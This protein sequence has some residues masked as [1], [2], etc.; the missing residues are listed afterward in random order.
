MSNLAEIVSEIIKELDE[1]DAVRE[2]LIQVSRAIVR[3]SSSAVVALHA[4]DVEKAD[5][6]LS[7]ASDLLKS[8]A[9]DL[10]RYPEYQYTGPM[11]QAYQEFSEANILRAIIMQQKMP[12]PRELSVPSPF[13]LSG[14]ADAIG[15]VRRFCLDLLRRGNVRKAVELL[16]LMENAYLVLRPLN[17][18][19]S[20][21]PGLKRRRDV[22]RRLVEETRRDITLSLINERLR[23]SIDRLL[24]EI[25]RNGK[26]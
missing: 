9:T 19:S 14:L 4:G 18:P 22:L 2:R 10:E 1:K 6:L 13:Y 17:E 5:R 12:T 25:E 8:I 24:R 20:L 15:E 7:E 16:K 3:A 26:D 21:I 11:P 23:K